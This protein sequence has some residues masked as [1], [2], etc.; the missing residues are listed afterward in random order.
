M[1]LVAGLGPRPPAGWAIVPRRGIRTKDLQP[2]SR[3][4]REVMSKDPES[5]P[6]ERPARSAG[7]CAAGS[8]NPGKSIQGFQLNRRT[9]V[10]KHPVKG[11]CLPGT[12]RSHKGTM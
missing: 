6:P 8:A 2:S 9:L 3:V 10:A 5:V 11:S 1:V 12:Q 4:L 7:V